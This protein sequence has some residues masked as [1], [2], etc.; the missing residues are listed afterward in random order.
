MST[1]GCSFGDAC[2]SLRFYVH[3]LALYKR[4]STKGEVHFGK[5]TQTLRQTHLFY[6]VVSSCGL[7]DCQMYCFC[8]MVQN[9]KLQVVFEGRLEKVV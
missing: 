9:E 8:I 3:C 7:K 2:Y 5:F 4:V 1:F 6:I